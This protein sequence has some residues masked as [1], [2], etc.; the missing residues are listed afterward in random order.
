M[1]GGRRH[2]GFG[3]TTLVYRETPWL[4]EDTKCASFRPRARRSLGRETVRLSW[5]G[6]TGEGGCAIH[7]LSNSMVKGT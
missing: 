4:L 5:D 1:L 3:G 2:A 6:V 7:H